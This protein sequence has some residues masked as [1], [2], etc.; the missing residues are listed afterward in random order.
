MP[1]EE[2]NSILLARIEERL[3]SV[4]DHL[5]TLEKDFKEFKVHYNNEMLILEKRVKEDYI[6]KDTFLPV[7]RAMFAAITTV[8]GAVAMAVLN[9]AFRSTN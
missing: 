5:V 6:T 8:V 2:E 1:T 3:K 4:Q 9:F 7:Q